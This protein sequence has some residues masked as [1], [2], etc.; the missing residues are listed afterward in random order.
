M[1]PNNFI[2]FYVEL[3]AILF[4]I[5]IYDSFVA[6]KKHRIKLFN[7]FYISFCNLY[8]NVFI[9]FILFVKVNKNAK[10]KIGI[11]LYI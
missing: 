5:N 11:M 1:V 3:L 7:L 8:Y 9:L 10:K 4:N 2:C 6:V